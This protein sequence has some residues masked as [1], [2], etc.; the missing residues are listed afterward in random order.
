M[1]SLKASPR[2]DAT[3]QDNWENMTFV[4]P[5]KLHVGGLGE[6]K[7]VKLKFIKMNSVSNVIIDELFLSL[8][9]L[10]DTELDVWQAALG[11]DVVCLLFS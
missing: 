1:S 9:K 5:D 10:A 11:V 7:G 6:C 3:R 4:K 8:Q 2:I